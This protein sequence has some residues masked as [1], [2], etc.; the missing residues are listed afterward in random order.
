VG[1]G[2]QGEERLALQAGGGEDR[3]GMTGDLSRLF[4]VVGIGMG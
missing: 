1:H 2:A 3:K 4:P